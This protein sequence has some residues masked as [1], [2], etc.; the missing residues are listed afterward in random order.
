MEK[1]LPG[2]TVE[3]IPVTGIAVKT[4]NKQTKNLQQAL[5]P[6]SKRTARARR[7]AAAVEEARL[8]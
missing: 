5:D 8:Q 1:E 6:L 2:I 4:F 3:N 7:G